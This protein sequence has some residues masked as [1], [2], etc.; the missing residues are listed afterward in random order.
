MVHVSRPKGDPGCPTRALRR[1]KFHSL[2]PPF[3]PGNAGIAGD[4]A[5]NLFEAGGAINPRELLPRPCEAPAMRM[6]SLLTS[7]IRRDDVSD[8]ASSLMSTILAVAYAFH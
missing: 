5:F 8:E 2:H 1:I 4:N 7:N 3:R 6:I